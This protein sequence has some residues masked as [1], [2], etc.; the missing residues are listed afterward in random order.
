MEKLKPEELAK[1][2]SRRKELEGKYYKPRPISE[3]MPQDNDF[4]A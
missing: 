4:M 3:F 1:W 2:E